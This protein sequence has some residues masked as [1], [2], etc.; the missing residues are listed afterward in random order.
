MLL[1][2][3][4]SLVL[5]TGFDQDATIQVTCA[6]VTL[7]IGMQYRATPVRVAFWMHDPRF[8]L[9]WLYVVPMEV[10]V[11]GEIVLTPTGF[12]VEKIRQ[13]KIL[14]I[15]VNGKYYNFD[16]TGTNKLID[17]DDGVVVE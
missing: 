14:K 12:W 7:D 13:Q 15:K 10:N 8:N 1:T 2:L 6:A 9:T 17:C 5:W 3:L 16:L 11:R 4:A